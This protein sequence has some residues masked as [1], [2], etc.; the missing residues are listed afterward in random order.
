M[1]GLAL[2]LGDT[3]GL[4]AAARGLGVLTAHTQTPIVTETPVV[5]DLLQALEVITDL[6]ID[7]VG[8]DLGGLAILYAEL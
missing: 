4:S 6:G 5:P 1:L 3:N 8:G 2:L 7:L